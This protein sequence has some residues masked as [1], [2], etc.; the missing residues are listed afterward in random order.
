MIGVDRYGVG[1]A[2]IA[3]VFYFVPLLLFW[4]KCMEKFKV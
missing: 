3:F 2:R 4:R 1:V